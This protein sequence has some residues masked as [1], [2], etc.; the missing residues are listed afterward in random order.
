VEKEGPDGPLPEE[1]VRI[2]IEVEGETFAFSITEIAK[3]NVVHR[4]E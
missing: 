4:H 3:A 2:K 1:Q